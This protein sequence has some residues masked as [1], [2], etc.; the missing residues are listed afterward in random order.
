[1][2]LNIVLVLI[3]IASLAMLIFMGN[4]E[5]K[6]WHATVTP[7]ASI[8]GSGFLVVAPLLH[9]IANTWAPLVMLFVVILAYAIG[10]VVRFNIHHFEPVLN[11]DSPGLLFPW[12]DRLSNIALAGAYIISVAFYLR[13]LAAFILEPFEFENDYLAKII[14]SVFI[15]TIALIG[16]IR[17]LHGLEK[18]ETIAVSIKLAIIIALLAGLMVFD[19]SWIESH[20]I[21]SLSASMNNDAWQTL[22]QLAGILLIVQG[23]E[24]SRYLGD[25]Y[26]RELRT[27][28]MKDAQIISG[29]IYLFF[30]GLSIPV[31][32]TFEQ[33]VS[34][35]AIIELSRHVATVLP[36]MLIFAAI[37]SQFGA[38]IADTVGTG[39]LLKETSGHR[40]SLNYSYVIVTGIALVLIW[41]ANIF[42]IIAYASRAFA[43]FYLMQ[44]VI[45][46]LLSVRIGDWRRRLLYQGYFVLMSLVLAFVVIFAIPAG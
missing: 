40:L 27:C 5:V 43:L 7:L 32:A 16:W 41:S 38:A 4:R 1:M 34:E 29:A 31:F 11:S 35:T 13:L 45:A 22:R 30:V 18:S 19:V 46:L 2:L 37:M 33:G 26:S 17:G 9:T 12:L 25:E 10:S 39:G 20:S 6:R 24:T 42:E 15:I 21:R 23:F 14:T 28:T 8:I 3:A 44:S 36:V